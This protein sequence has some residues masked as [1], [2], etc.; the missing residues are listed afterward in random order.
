MSCLSLLRT[1]KKNLK[2]HFDNVLRFKKLY[3]LLNILR[4]ETF[5]LVTFKILLFFL[6]WIVE[7]T[8]GFK[9]WTTFEELS[10]L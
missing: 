5:S 4:P 7:I 3:L 8:I 2:S 6:K 10:V 1:K 9:K